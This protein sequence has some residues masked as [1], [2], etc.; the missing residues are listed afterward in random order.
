[1][2]HPRAGAA[3]RGRRTAAA[4]S[5]AYAA[6]GGPA[7]ASARTPVVVAGVIGYFGLHSAIISLGGELR[8]EI[9]VIQQDLKHLQSDLTEVK[10]KIKELDSRLR[11][12][13][14]KIVSVEGKIDLLGSKVAHIEQK[15]ESQ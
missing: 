10:T 5:C 9:K 11:V 4:G 1:M 8:G 14:Q 7:G 2:R 3:G 15:I 12:V 6:R 13:E